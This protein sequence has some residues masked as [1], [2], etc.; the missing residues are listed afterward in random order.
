MWIAIILLGMT[1]G[2]VSTLIGFGAGMILAIAL[3]LAVSPLSALAVASLALLTGSLHR[4][5]LFRH[6]LQAADAYKWALGIAAGSIVGGMLVHHLPDWLLRVTFVA[7]AVVA[8]WPK[9]PPSETT[10]GRS[11]AARYRTMVPAAGAI[12][13]IGA[14]TAGVGPLASATLVATGHVGERYIALMAVTGVAL[15]AG[16]IVGYGTS[17]VLE[18]SS[19]WASVLAGGGLLAGNL[20]GKHVRVMLSSQRRGQLEK[21]VP[22][23]CLVLA[24]LGL[25]S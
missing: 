7:A 3:A 13:F 22:W 14:G 11:V 2:I 19:L 20:I 23:A 17:G 4:L 18:V 16:R 24:L 8:L 12:G 1:G 25:V 21:V 6:E 5:F 9:A 15:N 10:E